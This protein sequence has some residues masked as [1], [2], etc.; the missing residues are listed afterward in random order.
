MAAKTPESGT[1]LGLTRAKPKRGQVRRTP[2]PE[3]ADQSLAPREGLLA[4]AWRDRD[5]G[6][7]DF[8]QRV[9]HEALDERTPLLERLK[10]LAIFTSNLDEFYMKRVGLLRGVAQVRSEDD[11]VARGGSARERLAQIRQTVIGQL[12]EQACCY[13][14]L[15]PVLARHGI[16]LAEWEMLTAAQRE[17][18]S[19]FF[20]RNV[21]P[22]L[23][24][25]S[26]DPAHPFPF[27]SNLSTNWGFILRNPDT[28]EILPVRVKIP[29]ML[30]AWIP[31]KASGAPAERRF[32]SL[33]DLIRHSADKLFPGM[34]LIDASR[35]RI[36]RNAEIELDEEEESLREAVAEALQQRRFQPVVR[37]DLAPDAN[38][39]LRQGLMERFELRDDDVYEVPGLL[40]YTG[41]FQ[42]ASLDAP[43]LRDP[44]WVP[45]PPPRLPN[46]E[47]DI[48]AA[49]RSGDLLLH[50]PYESFDMSVEDFISDAAVDPHTVAIKMTVY[51]VGDDTPFVRSL[52]HAAEAGKQVAC[53]IELK[54]RFDE[55]RNLL[56]AEEL[57]KAGAHVTYGVLG[58]KT[59]TKVALVVRKE[60][61]DLR[62]Y[63][64]IG[65]GNYHVKTARLYT[66]VGL[67][68]CDP[69][70]TADVV[71][72][73]HYLTGCARTPRFEKLLVAPLNMR[74]RFLD[75]IE[76]EIEHQRAGR[77][78]RIIAKMNQVEDLDMARALAAASQAGVPVDLIVRGFCCL[79]PGV[80]GWTENVRVRSII[81]RFLE[82]SRIFFFA[83]GQADPLAGEYFIGSADWMHRNL[84]GRVEAA[85]PVEDRTA[86]ERLWEILDICL[87]DQRQAWLMQPDGSYVRSQPADDATGPAAVGTHAWFMDLARRRAPTG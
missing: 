36:L 44:H 19:R 77:P 53:V 14:D 35:F 8:N 81:G 1:S 63:A 30:P 74:Q 51:R 76:R 46:E 10:F 57:Q 31:L 83:N 86:R 32:L 38:P 68:T 87:Q 65:T 47:L 45:L 43:A 72:L 82:H 79:V 29:T 3:V 71:N 12:A 6:W 75:G 58:L 4:H 70:I 62:C 24:P 39:A 78:A 69:V 21:S 40:D 20:D 80:P 73:F 59:H 5:L 49:I 41:L 33:V 26:L 2:A 34:E 56:W 48:Y 16:I 28:D 50:H 55:A 60:G 13:R 25:L 84:S 85:T 54:A 67:L 52:I 11:P 23:T 61:A 22:A 37:M 18:A 66:D 42:I 15:V 9:L 27:V 7:L 17:E 64:H